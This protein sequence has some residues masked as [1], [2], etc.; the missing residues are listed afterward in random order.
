MIREGA[1]SVATT[2]FLYAMALYIL[3]AASL[4]GDARC[5]TR[6]LNIRG[7]ASLSGDAR[8][9]TRVLNI[10]GVASLSG[11][12]RKM[13]KYMSLAGPACKKETQS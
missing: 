1:Q 2:I 11:D 6:V 4:S 5:R 10:R 8:S 7:V 12:A 3:E 9:G 13:R